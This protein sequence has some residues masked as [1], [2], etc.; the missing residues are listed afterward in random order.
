MKKALFTLTFLML[1]FSFSEIKAQNS[2]EATYK[3]ADRYLLMETQNLNVPM[4]NNGAN[5]AGKKFNATDFL[6]LIQMPDAQR[7]AIERK[8][9]DTPNSPT[10]I[11]SSTNE[12]GDLNIIYVKSENEQYS[13][14]I[15]A[16]YLENTEYQEVKLKATSTSAFDLFLD[17]EKVLSS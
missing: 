3:Q 8:I 2:E 15:L 14:T 11:E 9:Y 4:F 12:E 10:W 16:G 17:G 7:A 13:Y 1:I 6:E 5:V